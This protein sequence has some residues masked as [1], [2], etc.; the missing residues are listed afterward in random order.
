MTGLKEQ[1]RQAKREVASWPKEWQDIIAKDVAMLEEYANFNRCSAA[2]MA[3]RNLALQRS[4][5]DKRTK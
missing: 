1:I 3:S 4:R 5:R 2:R